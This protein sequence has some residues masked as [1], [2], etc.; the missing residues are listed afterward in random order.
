GHGPNEA[1]LEVHR[2]LGNERGEYR[3]RGD[4]RQARLLKL[5]HA[6]CVIAGGH[7]HLVRNRLRHQV[8]DELPRVE[9]VSGRVLASTVSLADGDGEDHR[10]A[11]DAH[12]V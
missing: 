12:A 5:A 10:T 11:R 2:A 1:T 4:G 6:G 7:I 3:V 9:D 8:H